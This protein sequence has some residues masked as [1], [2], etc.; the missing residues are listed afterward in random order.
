MRRP[1]LAVS[2]WV[3]KYPDNMF[4]VV[5]TTEFRAIEWDLDYIPVPLSSHRC[6][7]L[8]EK[9]EELK[10][11]LRYHLP[12]STCDL[13]SKSSK[14]RKISEKYLQLNLE[15]IA[16]L[17]ADYAVLHFGQHEEKEIL[18][19][20]SLTSVIEIA[21]NYGITI[22]IENLPVGPTSHP[23]LLKQILSESGAELALD[24][25]HAKKANVFQELLS[26]LSSKT[27]HIHFY[28]S[29]DDSYNH[30]PFLSDSDALETASFLLR[31]SQAMWWTFEMSKL[32]ECTHLLDIFEKNRLAKV[33]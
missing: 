20:A 9:I 17:G 1:T 28:G 5:K 22:A 27:T 6:H 11:S 19:L 2:S 4:E 3:Y 32:D 33:P 16:R 10:I 29:E 7:Q 21:S 26:L 31:K 30:R 18:T 23:E 24:V 12:H 13:G 25:G 8:R 14:V 15:L